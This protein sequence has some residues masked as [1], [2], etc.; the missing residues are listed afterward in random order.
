MKLFI[1]IY[2][3]QGGFCFAALCD[4]PLRTYSVLRDKQKNIRSI[5][6]FVRLT[7]S[8]RGDDILKS[9]ISYTFFFFHFFHSVYSIN[10]F[11]LFV[12][13]TTTQELI[14]FS[15][16]VLFFPGRVQRET[17][18]TTDYTFPMMPQ[19]VVA[20]PMASKVL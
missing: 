19:T 6:L 20:R 4:T 3:A 13:A 11:E 17:F 14:A 15:E 10:T 1:F 18:A 12:G 9:I 5:V 7:S 16:L 8:W 2:W